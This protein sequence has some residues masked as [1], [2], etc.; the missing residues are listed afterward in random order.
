MVME[1]QAG[2]RTP[3]AMRARRMATW[4]ADWAMTEPQWT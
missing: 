4:D 3:L 2:G 1:R